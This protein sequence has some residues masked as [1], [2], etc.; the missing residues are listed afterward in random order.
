MKRSI[1]PRAARAIE[2]QV[3]ANRCGDEPERNDDGHRARMTREIALRAPAGA[4]GRLCLLGAG[5]ARDV[6]LVALAGQF[7]EIHLVDVDSAALGRAAARVP[8]AARRRLRAHAPVDVSGSWDDLD[9]W[10]G[11]PRPDETLGIE[12]E[13]AVARVLASLPGP[14]DVAV[15]CCMLAPLQLVVLDAVNERHPAFDALRA[16][17]NAIHVRVLA[18]LAGPSGRALLVTELTSDRTYPLD[19]LSADEDLGALMSDLVAVG[20][21]M[22]TAHPGLL[23][24]EIRRDP[25]LA[26]AFGVRFPVGPWLWHDGPDRIFLVY[27][28]EISRRRPA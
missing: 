14:F 21:V 5:N 27:G 28:M 20:N 4:A 25:V 17:Q 3:A 15:S 26:A 19:A 2:Q 13:P 7:A 23:S 6:D 22:S 8:E 16:L 24:A 9:E 11:R 18:G 1:S 10:A 12:V